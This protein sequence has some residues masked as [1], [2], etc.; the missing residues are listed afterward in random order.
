MPSQAEVVELVNAA[1]DLSAAAKSLS[2]L[3]GQFIA[4]NS[5]KSVDWG[6][7]GVEFLTD[8]DVTGTSVT[9]AEVSNVIGSLASFQTFMGTHGGNFE[10]LTAPIV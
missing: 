7:L 1:R 5:A 6:N 10:K 8:G 9:P 3:A 2:A 4:N